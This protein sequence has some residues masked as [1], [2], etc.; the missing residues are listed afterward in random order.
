MGIKAAL[1]TI[2]DTEKNNLPIE[3]LLLLSTQAATMLGRRQL[4]VQGMSRGER[5]TYLSRGP[6]GVGVKIHSRSALTVAQTHVLDTVC[7]YKPSA[8]TADPP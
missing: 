3:K 5:G 1:L 4:G 8:V 2:S 6:L 7:S